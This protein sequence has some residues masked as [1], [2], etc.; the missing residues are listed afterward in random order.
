MA[1]AKENAEKERLAKAKKQKMAAAKLKAEAKKKKQSEEIGI[2]TADQAKQF[3]ADLQSFVQKHPDKIDALKLA[4]FFTP[5]QQEIAAGN[6]AHAGSNFKKLTAVMAD[7]K[8]FTAH[9]GAGVKARAAKQAEQKK[10]SLG[11]IA[12]GVKTM[13]TLIAKN[14][15]AANAFDLIKLAKQYEK[16][17]DKKP[18]STLESAVT[19]LGDQMIKLGVKPPFAHRVAERAAKEK[20]EKA[21]RAKEAAEKARRAK[22]AAENTERVRL[23]KLKAEAEKKKLAAERAAK[24]AAEKARRAKEAAENT[25]R[26]RLAKLK[27]EAEKKKLAAAKAKENRKQDEQ[28][29]LSIESFI[30]AYKM[31]QEVEKTVAKAEAAHRAAAKLVSEIKKKDYLK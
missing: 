1:A 31:K 24:E 6:F 20:A 19:A 26:V 5:A 10:L 8:A 2:K 22:E 16:L 17:T 18:L 27:A 23:A 14:P 9:R 3:S 15:L 11:K 29:K 25:E 4:E 12:D 13:K 21:R 7:N 28:V 30:A